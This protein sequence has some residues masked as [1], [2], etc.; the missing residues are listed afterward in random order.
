MEGQRV[1]HSSDVSGF[2]S[3]FGEGGLC[4]EGQFLFGASAEDVGLEFF[5]FE[6]VCVFEP[7]LAREAVDGDFVLEVVEILEDAVAPVGLDLPARGLGEEGT[8]GAFHVFGC[9]GG[10]GIAH[11]H[12]CS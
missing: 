1:R 8:A 4:L 10:S 3:A 11:D 6:E 5:S 7:V 2:V 12:F 9:R